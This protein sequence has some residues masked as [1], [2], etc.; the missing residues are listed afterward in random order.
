MSASLVTRAAKRLRGAGK[1]FDWRYLV[2]IPVWVAMSYIA[3]NILAVGGLSV[4]KASSVYTPDLE[5]PAFNT[6]FA[7]VIYVLALTITLGGPW[8]LRRRLTSKKDLG[9][10]REL[11]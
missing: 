1:S 4:L 3:A 10:D 5:D 7:A 8:V 9:L 6:A 11:T 2:G